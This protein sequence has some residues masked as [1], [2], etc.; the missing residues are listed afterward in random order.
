MKKSDLYDI[1]IKL[2]GIGLL[3]ETI[4]MLKDFFMFV[5]LQLSM[6]DSEVVRSQTN[7]LIY[8]YAASI[9][10]AL[11]V[12][13]LLIFQS[14][15]IARKTFRSADNPPVDFTIDK[16]SGLEIAF[17]VIGGLMITKAVSALGYQLIR[18]SNVIQ[19]EFSQENKG[20]DQI[21]WQLVLI[22]IGFFVIAGRK[23]IAGYF[24]R[25][26]ERQK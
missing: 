18:L 10:V 23:S 11:I 24:V 8:G 21:I 17:V 1:A 5:G 2:F 16:R 13:F 14:R 7:A 20:F 22:I 9:A 4:S 15:W 6:S 19:S 12:A 3:I 26:D 25:R